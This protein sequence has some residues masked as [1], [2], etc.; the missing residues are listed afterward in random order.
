MIARTMREGLLRV[1]MLLAQATQNNSERTFGAK[2]SFSAAKFS[3]H[4]LTVRP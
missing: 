2:G 1:S 4:G 3:K